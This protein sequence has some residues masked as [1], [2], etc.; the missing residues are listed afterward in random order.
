[1]VKQYFDIFPTF[2]EL[3][4]RVEEIL[5]KENGEI[6]SITEISVYPSMCTK[7][8]FRFLITWRKKENENK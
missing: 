8:E 2:D 3:R 7:L 5:D 4:L 6:I 1:M